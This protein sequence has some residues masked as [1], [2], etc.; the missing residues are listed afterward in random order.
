MFTFWGRRTQIPPHLKTNYY[1]DQPP[2]EAWKSAVLL[3]FL[4]VLDAVLSLWLFNYPGIIEGNPILSAGLN[5]SPYL[6]LAI[7]LTLTVL[8][9]FILLIHWNFVIAR[10]RIRVVWLIRTFI[11]AYC[12]IVVYEVLLL[13]NSLESA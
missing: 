10:R 3:F 5:S 13:V 2:S 11:A 6:F 4:S 7:K 8:S 9:I 1:V 12:A